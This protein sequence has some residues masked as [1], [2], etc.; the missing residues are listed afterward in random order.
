MMGG[1]E[2]VMPF[3][4]EQFFDLFTR[5]N[6]AIW[7]AQWV[8]LALA[9]AVVI[10]SW[11][12]TSAGSRMVAAGLGVLW[13]W[14]GAAYHLAFFRAINPAATIFGVAF[15]LEGLLLVGVAL[16]HPRVT[17]APRR[18]VLGV[19]GWALVVYALLVYPALGRLAG[20]AYPATPTFGTPCPMTIF[21][22]GIFLWVKGRMPWWLLL[23]PG[24][25]AL[26]GLA[27]AL[28]LGVPQDVGLIAAAAIAIPAVLTRGRQAARMR[29]Q[30]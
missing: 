15:V 22:F 18:D 9:A 13:L 23:I 2:R 28:A 26:V 11:A 30:P 5:Y 19:L 27:A 12:R 29:T 7:P 17:F 25:W 21:T 3:T 4:T 8:L 14:A 20:H 6:T 10:A 1:K 24:I 16:G